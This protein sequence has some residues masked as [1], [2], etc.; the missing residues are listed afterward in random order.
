MNAAVYASA[1]ARGITRL[2]HFTPARNLFPL[3]NSGALVS[4]KRLQDDVRSFYNPTDLQRLDGFTD[5]VCCS[6]EYPNVWYLR[7]AKEQA[8]NYPD[9][10]V[11]LM[12]ASPLWEDGVGYCPRNASA[13][14][15]SLVRFDAAGFESM[16]AQAT[17]GAYNRTYVR[18]PSH[19][20]SCPTDNQAEVLIPGSI[21][22]DR[23]QAIAASS[24]EQANREYQRLK[25]LGADPGRFEFV[26]APLL[27]SA[28]ALKG[29][30]ESG[31][32]PDEVRWVPSPTSGGLT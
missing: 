22:L 10:V 25:M 32:R 30:I 17:T 13:G 15:G 21:G 18:G 14:S 11:L 23:L 19:L 5:H 24:T 16:F 7:K 9:W 29:A 31:R 27:F 1:T 8:A 3:L 28:Y 4:T 6:V 26:V 20:S 2:C 12:E